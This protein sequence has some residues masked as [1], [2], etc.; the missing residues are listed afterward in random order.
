MAEPLVI[1]A[2]GNNYDLGYTVGKS[3]RNLLIRALHDYRKLLPAEGWPS[4]FSLPAGYLHASRESYPHLVEELQGMADGAGLEL[5][6]LFFLNA[7]EEALDPNYPAACSSV[8]LIDRRGK[9]WLGHNE[10]WYARDA[11]AVIVI[12]A[13]PAG[14]PAF[15]SV[16]AAPFLAAVGVN[17]AGL[18]QGVNSVTSTDNRMGVPRM[19]LARAVLEA[20]TIEDAIKAAT[21]GKRAGGYNHLLVHRNGELGNLET[22]AEE[23]IYAAG[24]RVTF[25]TNHY[26]APGLQ[27]LAESA[28]DHSRLRLSRLSAAKQK[29]LTSD[30]PVGGISELLA[31]HENRPFSIC[32]HQ[33]EQEDGNATIFSTL[34]NVTDFKVWVAAGNPC[35]NILKEIT[36]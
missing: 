13:R 31:D 26:L 35:G 18:A 3:A 29:L 30:D 10:D 11:E 7:L 24:E 19:F 32:R 15:V 14:K 36:F 5:N 9:A 20:E 12:I 23:A 2:S 25:H 21:T 4:G 1:K 16:T 6:H 28:S 33:E 17:E 8:G 22:T 27:R 34:F